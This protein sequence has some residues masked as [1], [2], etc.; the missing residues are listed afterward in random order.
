MQEKQS[1]I[2]VL[3]LTAILGA[4]GAVFFISRNNKQQE[5]PDYQQDR[6]TE[7]FVAPDMNDSIRI[8]SP[9]SSGQIFSPVVI[10][11]Q[12]KGIWFFEA[13]FPVKLVDANEKL[14]AQGIAT[15]A[16][17]WMTTDFVPFRA[18]LKF[19]AGNNKTGFIIMEKDNPSGLVENNY[20]IKIPV[21]F[22]QDSPEPKL[23]TVQD[24]MI[25]VKVFFNH[26]KLDPNFTDGKVFPVG[27]V[28]PKTQAVARAA[29]EELLKGPDEKEKAGG[30]FTS[31]NQ[32]VKIQKLSIENGIARIDFDK[33]IEYQLGGSARVGAIRSQIT[34]TLKQFPT[35]KEVIISVDGRVEDAIQP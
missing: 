22:Q 32:G 15:A 4:A 19:A 33:Q 7:K 29:V 20:S 10:E 24:N 35:V 23:L 30:Y 21:T 5:L 17:D 12:A 25:M 26:S 9:E 3:I 31:I 28:L 14:L 1:I 27:R 18:E 16:A 11:G 6:P 2:P 13:S 8:K 34:E